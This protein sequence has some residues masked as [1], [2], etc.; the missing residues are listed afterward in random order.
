M[1]S[2]KIENTQHKKKKPLAC[3]PGLLTF[4]IY[5]LVSG[6]CLKVLHSKTDI[7]LVFSEDQQYMPPYFSVKFPVILH[8]ANTCI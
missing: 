7:Q 2:K 8:L 6:H 4:L 3:G 1:G 5:I